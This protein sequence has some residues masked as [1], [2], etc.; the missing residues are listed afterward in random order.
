MSDV[1]LQLGIYD[2][3]N[4]RAL[5]PEEVARSFIPSAH[6]KTLVRSAHT[7]VVG[8]RGSGKTTL[9]KMLQQ[10]A[11]ENWHHE[12]S[13]YYRE[14]INF[15]GVFVATDVSWR[16]QI[17]ALGEGCLSPDQNTQLSIA[18]FTTHVLRAL[19]TSME[20]RAH[21]PLRPGAVPHRRVALSKEDE[22][23]I[24][25]ELA[26]PWNLSPTLPS[27]LSLKY[28]LS[29]RLSDIRK[30]AAASSW[31]TTAEIAK[32]I[33]NL[34]YLHLDFI[35]AAELATEVFDDV[36]TQNDGKWAF[37]FD[38]LELAPIWI[39]KK[40]TESLRSV[41][42][43]FL[44]KLSMSPFNRELNT[45]E[46]A[47]SPAQGHDFD[48]ISLWYAHKE[49]GY[50]FCDSLFQSI[51]KSRGFK[52]ITPEDIL[53]RS[54][55]ETTHDEWIMAGTA[56]FPGSRIQQRFERLAK[57]D[58]TFSRYLKDRNLDVKSLVVAES[59]IRAADIRKIAS[60]VVV[61]E[62]YRG[63]EDIQSEKARRTMRSRK[64]PTLYAGA[65]SL[66]A[67]SEGNP[68]WLKGLLLSV[69][70]A[71]GQRQKADASSQ[72]TEILNTAHR[73]RALLR[74]IPCPPIRGRQPVRGMIS[75]MDRIGDYF[76]DKAVRDNFT[77]EPP[78]SFVVDSRTDP[79]LI[80]SL[81]RALNSGAIVYVPEGTGGLCLLNDLRGRRF[82]LCYLLASYYRLP[83]VLG[84][85]A[86][87]SSILPAEPPYNRSDTLTY[88]NLFSSNLEQ[89]NDE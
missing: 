45:F 57:V 65:K 63:G 36:T 11:I 5:Q 18:T 32:S 51:A 21:S 6:Y 48:V 4:A 10:A 9:L 13:P 26:G 43:R 88:P 79:S 54:E 84:K 34:P 15:T 89:N 38:E 72:S 19:I 28:S 68:R 74:T 64:N 53:G 61:R 69:F 33:Q 27:L 30:I 82:R 16:E 67:I 55:F 29:S 85:P 46:T 14:R 17:N 62:T 2:A 70:D 12:E 47:I 40:L 24:V 86:S 75:L 58:R 59:D 76:F 35:T 39:L 66:F 71:M 49:D 1:Q 80:D 77:P 60:L 20:Y 44:F 23:R 73:F 42:Q 87:L 7:L 81:G 41:N 78:G 25:K 37:L 56:Y 22:T 3:F 31:Q 52:N 8:P 83:L 50:E